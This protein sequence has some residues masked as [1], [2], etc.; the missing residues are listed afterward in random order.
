MTLVLFSA[1]H[2]S[3][4]SGY[5]SPTLQFAPTENDATRN[6]KARDEMLGQWNTKLILK[7]FYKTKG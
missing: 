4:A 2:I 6:L 7:S 5:R 1:H 3:D